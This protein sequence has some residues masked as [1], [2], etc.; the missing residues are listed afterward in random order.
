VSIENASDVSWPASRPGPL[1]RV[2]L[3]MI[4]AY[5]V[6]LSPL[7]GGYCRYL[8]TCSVYAQEAIRRHGARRGSR[9]AL[10]R[11]LRCHPFHPG[12]HDPVP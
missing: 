5:R 6:T 11:L 12:G 4:E 3:L 1:A 9:L 10:G 7:V 8:P 2:L